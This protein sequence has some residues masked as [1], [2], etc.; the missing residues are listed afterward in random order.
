MGRGHSTR[1]GARRLAREATLLRML[2]GAHES[3]KGGLHLALERAEAD[4]CRA[5]QIFTKNSN[6]WKE[7]A[8]ADEQ[9]DA[10]RVARAR[11]GGAVMAHTSYLIN[12]AA[13]DP[14]ILRKSVDALE[15]EVLRSSALGVDYV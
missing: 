12:L 8:L 11:F 9:L 4:G 5:L 1:W 3:V 13:S 10:F 6:Q 14:E 15:T 7:P 2:C